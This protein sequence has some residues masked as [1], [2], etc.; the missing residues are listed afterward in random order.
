ML[1]GDGHCDSLTPWWTLKLIRFCML[2][3]KTNMR[4]IWNH[5][6]WKGRLSKDPWSIDL[7]GVKITEVVTDASTAVIS[8]TGRYN[9]SISPTFTGFSLW[10]YY[11]A[12]AYP[13]I[14]HSLDVWY[15]SKKTKKG[16]V[17][18]NMKMVIHNDIYIQVAFSGRKVEGDGAGKLGQ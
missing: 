2:R 14:H 15:T 3:P 18:V 12:S 5:Q 4:S 6:T 13:N 7:Q 9:F 8:T 16:L 10:N 17:E 1:C 11:S